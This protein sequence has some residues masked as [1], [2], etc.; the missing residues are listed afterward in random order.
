[1]YQMIIAVMGVIILLLL[2]ILCCCCCRNST[3]KEKVTHA[4]DEGYEDTGRDS[5]SN[6]TVR[7]K[8]KSTKKKEGHSRGNSD[9]N[10]TNQPMSPPQR[11]TTDGQPKTTAPSNFFHA[12][13]DT[14]S[15]KG[16]KKSESEEDI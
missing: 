13:S 14:P 7:K 8:K 12:V 15:A 4:K 10:V 6:D 2:C 16:L 3:K 5:A 11:E 1:M 9:L